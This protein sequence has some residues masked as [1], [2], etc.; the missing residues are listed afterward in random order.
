MSVLSLG[1]SQGLVLAQEEAEVEMKGDR[2]W[3]IIAEYKPVYE[4]KEGDSKAVEQKVVESKKKEVSQKKYWDIDSDRKPV[5]D[6]NAQE[7]P[8]IK[9]EES[10][11]TELKEEIKVFED[12]T[13]TIEFNIPIIEPVDVDEKPKK[14]EEK[15]LF[16][17]EM[18][19]EWV[20]EAV[21][22]VDEPVIELEEKVTDEDDQVIDVDQIIAE[23]AAENARKAQKAQM[24]RDVNEFE[25]SKDLAKVEEIIQEGKVQPKAAVQATF[26]AEKK[27]APIKKKKLTAYQRDMEAVAQEV[28]YWDL[29]V[30]EQTIEEIE[31]KQD[32]TAAYE[33]AKKLE[34]KIQ[35][36]YK[37]RSNNKKLVKEEKEKTPVITDDDILEDIIKS[38]LA[39]IKMDLDFDDTNLSDVILTIGATGEVNIVLDPALKNNKLDLH[40]NQVSIKEALL[41]VANTYDLGFKR[42]VD[43]L[44]ITK[45][46]NLRDQNLV[47]KVIKLKNVSVEEIKGLIKDLAHS[48][49]SSDEINSLIVVGA[50]E[51]VVKIQ[52]I[53]DQIDKPQPQV[54]LEAKI[55]ELNKDALKDLGVDWSDEIRLSYQES[56]RDADFDDI[57]DSQG[58]LTEL[59]SIDRNPLQFETVIKM[60]ESQN[61]AKVLSNPRITTLNDKRAEIFVGD[62]IPYTVTNVTG[63]VVTTDVRWVE[64]G[65]RLGITP[66]IIEDDFVVIKIEP[67]VSFIFAFRGPNDEFPQVKTRE[68]VANV[69]VQ[70][71]RPFILGGIL[72]QEDKKNLFKVPVLGNVPLLGN[73]FSY[74]T[75]S[76]LDTELIITIIPT[77]VHGTSKL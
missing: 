75:H 19:K 37:K 72:S 34:K 26:A 17:K 33:E 48:V 28:D 31:Y 61:K 66:S 69:R 18:K 21:V 3:D 10:P 49:T 71:N 60:L 77:I 27:P 51:E 76:V 32:I 13:E 52:K 67:E 56:A 7:K 20:E 45:R 29:P 38:E 11:K 25:T 40:L 55:I 4:E 12:T 30:D 70:N 46:E 8:V 42:I 74:E 43:S 22:A 35:H 53:V 54:I 9:K 58:K 41:L 44:Y 65:I 39:G 63:G 73:L 24:L 14:I 50:P 23:V 1:L 57:T 36:F 59:F 6:H 64:P 15:P 2:L 5:F 62:E 68:A 16:V 47:S